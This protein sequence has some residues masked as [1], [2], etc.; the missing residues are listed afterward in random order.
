MTTIP[1]G[2]NWYGKKPFDTCA[3]KV[4]TRKMSKRCLTLRY[5]MCALSQPED[6]LPGQLM[7]DFSGKNCGMLFS[8][9]GLFLRKGQPSIREMTWSDFP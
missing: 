4:D 6:V 2:R 8:S 5:C 9:K 3:R 1:R 7:R